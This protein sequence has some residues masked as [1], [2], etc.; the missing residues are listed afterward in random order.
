MASDHACCTEAEK[1]EQLRPARP[2]FGGTAL[3]HPVLF[4]AGHLKRGPFLA[5]VAGPVSANSAKAYNL[6]GGLAVGLDP[7]L[8]P[9]G[10]DRSPFEG[11]DLTGRP[12][13][14]VVGG[15][16]RFRDGAVVGEPSG[17][18]ARRA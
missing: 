5:R 16:V 12:V 4:S 6:K 15:Q 17:Q 11:V 8:C 9:S 18:Y 13:T 2:G 14:T 7:E 3:L 10:Q 1:G